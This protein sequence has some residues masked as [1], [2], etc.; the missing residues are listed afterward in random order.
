[1]LKIIGI[2]FGIVGVFAIF[3]T[4]II[5]MATVAVNITIDGLNMDIDRAIIAIVLV[6][7]VSV[8][9]IITIDGVIMSIV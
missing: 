3:Y 2:L 6:K 4:I 1:M 9:P 5:I 7:M 8:V